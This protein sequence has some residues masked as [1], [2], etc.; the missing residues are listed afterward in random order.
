MAGHS[1]WPLARAAPGRPQVNRT[2]EGLEF[3]SQ[4]SGLDPYPS[5]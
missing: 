3:R 2:L 1:P 4:L 5:S